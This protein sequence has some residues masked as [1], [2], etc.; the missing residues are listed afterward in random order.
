MRLKIKVRPIL[1]TDL[2]FNPDFD[3]NTENSDPVYKL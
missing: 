1:Q 2:R 3:I